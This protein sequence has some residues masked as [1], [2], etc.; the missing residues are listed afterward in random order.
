MHF[1]KTLALAALSF[2]GL[3]AAYNDIYAREA[4]FDTEADFHELSARFAEPDLEASH[5]SSTSSRFPC[6]TFETIANTRLDLAARDFHEA[7]L[8]ERE[9]RDE[10]MD[11]ALMKRDAAQRL[12]AREASYVCNNCGKVQSSYAKWCPK[13]GQ[14]HP[15]VAV[16][17]SGTVRKG[18]KKTT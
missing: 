1:S 7:T 4:D 3:T 2:F 11:I 6:S 13:C 5:H 15:M 14:G 10:L 16:N 18:S 12:V 17:F 9:L 8:R